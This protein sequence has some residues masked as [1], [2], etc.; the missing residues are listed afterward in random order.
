MAAFSWTTCRRYWYTSR[1]VQLRQNQRRGG[2]AKSCEAT[3]HGHGVC[4]LHP[5]VCA[6]EAGYNG[7]ACRTINLREC[8]HVNDGLWHASHCAGEC[9]E[10]T[11]YCWCPGRI[12]ERPMADTCQV[13]HMSVDAFAAFTLKPDPAWIRFA[14]DGS[15]VDGVPVAAADEDEDMNG[16][17]RICSRGRIY[18]GRIRQCARRR[19]RGFGLAIRAVAQ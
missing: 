4:D 3:C 14:A 10:R 18:S 17:P 15:K 2:R 9:D 16:L 7:S 8:N 12:G 13:K 6:C 11:G 1:L 5:G 19:S